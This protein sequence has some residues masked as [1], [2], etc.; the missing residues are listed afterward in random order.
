MIREYTQPP[1]G[2]LEDRWPQIKRRDQELSEYVRSIVED[3]KLRGDAGSLEYTRRFDNVILTQEDLLVDKEE[4]KDSYSKVSEE[5][6]KALG[7]AKNRLMTVEEERLEK[8]SFQVSLEDV[9]IR[10]Q[11]RPLGSVGCY[12]PGGKAPYPSSL[13]MNVVPAKVAGVK[14]IVVTTPP[15]KEGGVDPLTLVAADICDVD[16]VYRLGGVQ[17][18]ASLAYG[19]EMI[20]RVDKIVG[21]GNKYVTEAKNTVS[22][23]VAIDKPA[24]PSEILILADYS[25]DPKLIALDLI[26]QAEHGVGGYSGLVTP[27][28]SL[29]EEVSKELIK[30]LNES[31]RKKEVTEALKEGG[32]IYRCESLEEAIK[33]A[34]QFAPEHLEIMTE[35]P[36]SI[37]DNISNSGLILLGP[38]SPVSATDYCI[39]VNH[40][41]PTEGYSKL[42]GGLTVLDFIKPVSIVTI[43]LEGLRRVREDI[44][45]LAKAEGHYNHY[46]A[47]EGRFPE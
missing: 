24:G 7:T 15:T 19:T 6:V 44:K 2:I 11:I 41:L 17:A 31:P 33:F 32:F 25:G 45:A 1:E 37:V 26:S 34:N 9:I 22:N 4:I 29:A 35:D 39:G 38:Y 46:R 28:E 18:I 47:V 20:G 14:R 23:L 10:N 12:V 40:I 8:L 21:P 13:V 30:A 27:S 36:D 3:I 43:G 5:A 42:Y 16:E